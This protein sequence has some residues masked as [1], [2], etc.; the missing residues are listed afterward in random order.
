MAFVDHIG[1][2]N[3]IIPFFNFNISLNLTAS[4]RSL[5]VM[6]QLS[7]VTLYLFFNAFFTSLE[8]GTSSI[9]CSV[10]NPTLEK[11]IKQLSERRA[12]DKLHV[13]YLGGGGPQRYSPGEGGLATGI[14]A[15]EIPIELVFEAGEKYRVPLIVA[16]LENGASSNGLGKASKCPLELAMVNEYYNVVVTLLQYNAD[17]DCIVSKTGDSLLHEALKQTF[18]TGGW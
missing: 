3:C 14:D 10:P 17:P 15:S 8:D 6:N 5:C 13:L 18:T 16:L 9:T 12:W 11:L 7:L 1:H 2:S 4:Y